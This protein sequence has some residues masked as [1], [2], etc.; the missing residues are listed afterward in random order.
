MNPA[1]LNRATESRE[2]DTCSHCHKYV[3]NCECERCP[4]CGEV[5]CE[6]KPQP[7]VD[8]LDNPCAVETL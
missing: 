7:I 1:D 6:C 3:W 5:E 2:S 8:A 4:L